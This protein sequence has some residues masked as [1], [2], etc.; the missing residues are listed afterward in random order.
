MLRVAGADGGGR[1]RVTLCACQSQIGQCGA[2]EES[3]PV[4]EAELP[5]E[6]PAVTA[7]AFVVR[8]GEACVCPTAPR[9]LKNR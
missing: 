7:T 3:A 5:E 8:S 6:A 9:G 1:F 2:E 4:I